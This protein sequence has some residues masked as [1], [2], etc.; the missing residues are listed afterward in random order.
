MKIITAGL[1]D[2]GILKGDINELLETKAYE[3]FYMHR[4]GHWLGLDT[5]DVGQYKI[6]GNWRK[7]GAGMVLTVEPGIYISDD[8]PGVHEEWWNTGIRIE[9]DV[10]ITS[11][12]SEVLTG[13]LA[14]TVVGIEALMAG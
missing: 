13:A 5:H 11:K 10:A 3:R 4:S 8:I 12:G 14:K 2:L 1:L 9:D 6:N 7:L